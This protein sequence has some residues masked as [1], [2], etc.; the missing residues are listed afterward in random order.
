MAKR[1][2]PHSQ[3]MLLELEM[4]RTCVKGQLLHAHAQMVLS[5]QFLKFIITGKGN[6]GIKIP[7]AQEWARTWVWCIAD[8]CLCHRANGALAALDCKFGSY[9]VDCCSECWLTVRDHH[10]Q[11]YLEKAN[12]LRHY[13]VYLLYSL[14]ATPMAISKLHEASVTSLSLKLT[15][16]PS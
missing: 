3:I 2:E 14:L 7:V 16:I 8:H 4:S 13:K 15:P 9:T 6:S 10:H 11:G 5:Q 12:R 1:V